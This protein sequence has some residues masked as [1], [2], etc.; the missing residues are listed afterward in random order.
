MRTIH[1]LPLVVAVSLSSAYAGKG[2]GNAAA[3]ATDPQRGQLLNNP[4]PKLGSYSPSDLLSRLSGSDF[5][6]DLVELTFSPTCSV[7]VYQL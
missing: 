7:D 5:V 4:P 3:A 6:Q 1:L 2:S